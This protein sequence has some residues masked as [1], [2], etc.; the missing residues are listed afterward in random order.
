MTS[1]LALLA[2][3]AAMLAAG[4]GALGSPEPGAPLSVSMNHAGKACLD[5]PAAALTT[6]PSAHISAALMP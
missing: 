6:P 3:A 5:R 4:C 1:A 2:A